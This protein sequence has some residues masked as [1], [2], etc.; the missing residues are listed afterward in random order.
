MGIETGIDIRKLIGIA[1]D[2]E[3]VL[4]HP[5]PGQVMKAG[6][7]LDLHPMESVRTAVG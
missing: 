2:V 4:G 6:L 3:P 5:L 7:R 1:R